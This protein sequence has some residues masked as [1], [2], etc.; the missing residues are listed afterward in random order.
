LFALPAPSP[1]TLHITR[2]LRKFL[3]AL[4]RQ[5]GGLEFQPTGETRV[6]GLFVAGEVGGG[7]HGA[8]RLMG[9]SLLDII[10]FGRIAG[11]TASKFISDEVKDGTLTLEHVVKYNDE[12]AKAGIADGR[13]A[14]AIIPDYTDPEVRER[15]LTANYVGN[16]R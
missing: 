3:L 2:K 10:V 7:I 4:F 14:P 1:F 11:T 5:N 8:N 12:V 9:N 16:V 6:P 15:Q 13:V